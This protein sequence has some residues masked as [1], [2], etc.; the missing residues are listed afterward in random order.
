MDSKNREKLL[1]I[2]TAL[3]GVLWLLNWLVISP[4]TDSWHRRSDRIA[5]LRKNI[6]D[7]KML[8]RRGGSIRGQWLR[9]STNALS[10]APTV[11][12]RQLFDAF[13]RWVRNSGVTEGAFN[14]QLKNTDDNYS[15]IECHADVTG[16][17]D[18]IL[19][20]LYNVE[21]DPMGVQIEAANLTSRDD[22]GQQISLSM[23]LS[24]LLLPA[25]EDTNNAA[26]SIA[27]EDTAAPPASWTNFQSIAQKN[28]FDPT[29]AGIASY[30]HA[31]R[32]PVIHSFTYRGGDGY[33]ALF[34]GEGTSS[35]GY[36]RVGDTIDGFT[37]RKITLNNGVKLTDPSGNIEELQIDESMRRVDEGP[38]SKSEEAAPDTPSAASSSPPSSVDNSSAPATSPGP[39]GDILALLKKRKEQ[40]K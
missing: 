3:C 1:L 39:G 10:S 35:K 16:S 24:G 14:P 27:V 21:S 9:M 19:R 11:A 28:V 6:D 38:W 2:I 5:Q 13:D 36:F 33:A 7:G 31:R 22:T 29:R 37:I 8:I 26:D 4:L 15:V 20:F 12:E 30:T 17:Y 32:E 34:T 18:T 23:E 40:E 25:S